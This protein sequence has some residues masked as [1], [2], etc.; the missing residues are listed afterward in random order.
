MR[1]PL[2]LFVAIVP[3]A[4]LPARLHALQERLRPAGA[5]VKWVE[6]QNLHV[7]LKFLGET[8]ETDL[9]GVK[10]VLRSLAPTQAPFHLRLAG[11]GFF[12]PRGTPRVVWVGLD[13]GFEALRH[14][15]VA[16]ESACR[17]LG[18]APEDRPFAAHLTLGRV[19]STGHEDA[20]KREIV[21]L[22]DDVVGSFRVGGFSLVESRLTPRG[23]VYTHVEDYPLSREI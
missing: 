15:H 19:R 8:P 13:E 4:P 22:R 14:L 3:P 23:P 7:T 1:R 17:T 12:P 10:D 18:F 5:D 20:L 6:A 16:V 21:K 11:A 2:R 9:P